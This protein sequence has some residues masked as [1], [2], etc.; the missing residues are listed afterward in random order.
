VRNRLKERLHSDNY[1]PYLVEAGQVNEAM[2]EAI[3]SIAGDKQIEN[4]LDVD[5]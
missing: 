1:A 2:R 4:E 5:T 3:V